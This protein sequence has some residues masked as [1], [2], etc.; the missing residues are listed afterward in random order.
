MWPLSRRRTLFGRIAGRITDA[1]TGEALPFVNV[2]IMGTTL[3][4]A[5]DIDGYYSIL[6]LRP[7]TYSVKV[8]A[9]GYQSK[10]VENVKISIDLTTK[11]D[12]TILEE[13]IELGEEVVVIPPH[14]SQRD[15]LSGDFVAWNFRIDMRQE[16]AL[17]MPGNPEL[18]IH[19]ISFQRK[20]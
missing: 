18:F 19:G 12:L 1:T 15:V 20:T 3:G 13:S 17:D 11:I 14:L 16:I 8:S 7:G 5:S 4:A 9:I 6:N 2:V 10:T